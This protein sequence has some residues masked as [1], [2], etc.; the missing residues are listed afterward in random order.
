MLRRL[1]PAQTRERPARRRGTRVRKRTSYGLPPERRC[2]TPARG[3]LIYVGANR[4]ST[5]WTR[6]RSRSV[7]FAY[8]QVGIGSHWSG[9]FCGFCG[10]ESVREC[11]DCIRL[12]LVRLKR[13]LPTGGFVGRRWAV[14]G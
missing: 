8:R 11:G 13:T 10:K 9:C 4:S 1:A 12:T 14:R 5:D 7:V 6:P 2:A 3:D